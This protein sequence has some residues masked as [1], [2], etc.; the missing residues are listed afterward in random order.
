MFYIEDGRKNFYQWDLDRKITCADESITQVHF[1]YTKDKVLPVEVEDDEQGR[2]F[3]VPNILL[4]KAGQIRLYGYSVSHT[5]I[6]QQFPILPRPKPEDYIYTEEDYYTI[7]KI[8][9]EKLLEA[10]ESGDFKGEDGKDGE[11]G[12]NGITPQLRTNATSNEWEVSYDNG[13]SWASLGVKA[14]GTNGLNGKDGTDGEDG[15]DGVDGADGKDGSTPYIQDGY[16]YINGESTGVKAEGID[17]QDGTNGVD[18]VDGKTPFIGDNGN[19]WIGDTDTGVKAQVDIAQEL[20]DSTEK[21]ISQGAFTMYLKWMA[22]ELSREIALK[23]EIKDV[24]ELP[25][26]MEILQ[27]SPT[28]FYRVRNTIAYLSKDGKHTEYKA[29]VHFSVGEPHHGITLW[30]DTVDFYVDTTTGKW[31]VFRSEAPS[32][33]DEPQIVRSKEEIVDTNVTYLLIPNNYR[34][35]LY[36]PDPDSLFANEPRFAKIITDYE[37]DKAVGDIDTALDSIIEIQNSLIGEV[38]E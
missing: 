12:A 32:E 2:Y 30:G 25:E 10:K 16:W 17:G 3:K 26:G 11:D 18:G 33:I 22:G 38:A 4:Q 20:G 15:R 31:Y 28:A 35:K 19:W 37:F 24:A 21:A 6:E 13:A 9:T 7:E 5:K 1:Y 34:S 14:T 27:V 29:V 23:S 8:V 36:I